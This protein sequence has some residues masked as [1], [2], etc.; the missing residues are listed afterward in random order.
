ML[1]SIHPLL[2]I[3]ELTVRLPDGQ[4][5]LHN[6]SLSLGAERVGLVG[7]NGSGK[8]TLLRLLAGQVLQ[9]GALVQRR[10]T[11]AWLDQHRLPTPGYTVAHRL[12]VADVYAAL[13]RCERGTARPDDLITIGDD[14]HLP[15]RVQLVLAPLGLAYLSLDRADDTLSGGERSRLALAAQLLAKPDLLLLDEPTNDLDAAGRA[16]VIATLQQWSGG[17]LVASHDR[18][19]LDTMYRIVAIEQHSLRAYGGGYT[20]YM[21]QRD[22][23]R[24]RAVSAMDQADA[25]LA[26]ARQ[27]TQV[28]RERQAHRDAKGRRDRSTGSQPKTVLNGMRER[29][30]ATGAR[31]RE[32]TARAHAEA[33]EQLRVARA[34]VEQR[35]PFTPVVPTSNLA[36]GTRVVSLE[37]VCIAV[38][39]HAPLLTDVTFTVRGPAR[40]ALGGPNG[41][42][43]STLLKAIVGTHRIAAGTLT[44]G[45]AGEALVY[46]DQHALLLDAEGSVLDAYMARHPKASM[47]AVRQQLA[48]F[49][50]RAD[51]AHR[52]VRALSGGE[53]VR[54]ALAC[55]L[56]VVPGR[57]MP[58][59]LVLDEPTNHLDL[60]S[61]NTLERALQQWDGALLVVS[62]DRPFLDA[63]G[64]TTHYDVTQWRW[65]DSL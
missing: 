11:L 16:A 9:T 47:M 31:I 57:P 45:I 6:V 56:G 53:R 17:V 23:E 18:A 28:V 15:E 64:V 62:H 25:A 36:A 60:D 40:V 44:H 50:F 3:R 41:C 24:E 58:Q 7:P 14:W 2:A 63:I 20:A 49:G 54:A 27:Q 30:Q 59:C 26:R 33:T 65:P 55:V 10:G 29:S 38:A 13:T 51:V 48:H 35:T 21:A 8:S 46:L 42:G 12:G 4:L 19:L 34:E 1:S 61:Q 52:P 39:A 43:K 22:A 37:Q 5:L 32:T